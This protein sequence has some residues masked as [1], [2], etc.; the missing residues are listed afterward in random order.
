MERGRRT[1]NPR[2]T[3]IIH[4]KSMEFESFVW[5]DVSEMELPL[6]AVRAARKEEMDYVE[7]KPF[8]VVKKADALRNTGEAPIGA[9]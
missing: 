6:E 9:K 4:D 7:G 2:I 1:E 8:K 5:C 3:Q